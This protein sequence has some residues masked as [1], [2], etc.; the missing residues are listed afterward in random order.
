[1]ETLIG[2]IAYDF[3]GRRHILP[4]EEAVA[5]LKSGT[6]HRVQ[7][8]CDMEWGHVLGVK[9]ADAT[10]GLLLKTCEQMDGRPGKVAPK[11]PGTNCSVTPKEEKFLSTMVAYCTDSDLSEGTGIHIEIIRLIRQ[12][13]RYNRQLITVDAHQ[14][15]LMHENMSSR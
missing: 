12:K 7:D 8:Y 9:H 13:T 2:D 5:I 6:P 10:S 3:N 1:M 11:G 4:I 14:V 15:R